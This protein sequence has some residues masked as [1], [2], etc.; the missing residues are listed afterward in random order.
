MDKKLLEILVCP[1]CHGRL[2]YKADLQELHCPHD[3]IAFPVK[4]NIPV[5]LTDRARSLVDGE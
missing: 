5:L 2:S 1:L 3:M 4:D